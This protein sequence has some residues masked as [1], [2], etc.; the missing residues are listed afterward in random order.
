MLSCEIHPKHKKKWVKSIYDKTV[1]QIS[2]IFWIITIWDLS[3]QNFLVQVF[4]EIRLC[5]SVIKHNLQNGNCL[6]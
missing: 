4:G 2:K 6:S 3:I 1:L 5:S